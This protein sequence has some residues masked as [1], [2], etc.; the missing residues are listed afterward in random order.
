ML[1]ENINKVYDVKGTKIV[2][3]K[4][5]SFE[6]QTKGFYFITGE[7]GSGKSTLLNIIGG[8]E[9]ASSGE[10]KDGYSL[11]E[12]G[13]VFQDNNLINEYT[14]KDNLLMVGANIEDVKQIL[15]KFDLLDKLNIQVKY[16]SGGE[17]QRIS[18]AR[19]IL[20][21]VKCLL[22]DEITS[23]L[24]E[25]NAKLIFE[26][27]KSLANDMLVILVSHDY[28]NAIK[29]CD[30]CLSMAEGKLI[31]VSTYHNN[32]SSNFHFQF[33]NKTSQKFNFLWQVKYAFRLLKNRLFLTFISCLIM[34]FC[35]ISIFILSSYLT[36]NKTAVLNKSLQKKDI[37]FLDVSTD[38]SLAGLSNRKIYKGNNLV[39]LLENGPA[40]VY[41]YILG[42]D[43]NGFSFK[44]Y[45]TNDVNNLV[46]TDY[47]LENIENNLNI[48]FGS[49]NISFTYLFDNCEVLNTD[50]LKADEEVLVS[51]YSF[52]FLNMDLFKEILVSKN[53]PLK[54][55]GDIR[56]AN[57]IIEE[58]DL[59][60]PSF[61]KD[62]FS[63]YAIYNSEEIIDGSSI[64]NKYD[65]VTS[66]NISLGKISYYS[67][68]KSDYNTY[69][70]DIID[71]S[72]IVA[73]VNITGLT[74]NNSS[75]Y[76]ISKEFY[77]EIIDMGLAYLVSGYVVDIKDLNADSIA[78]M[79][80]YFTDN[81]IN[82][83]DTMYYGLD[84]FNNMYGMVK[85]IVL[86]LSL[87][88]LIVL[89]A[90]LI[91][92]INSNLRSKEKEL[93]ILKIYGVRPQK[94]F[95]SLFMKETMTMVLA[96]LVGLLSS[97]FI[98]NLIDKKIDQRYRNFNYLE[99]HVGPTLAILLG[100]V[101]VVLIISSIVFINFNRK[102]ININLKNN[103]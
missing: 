84:Y 12:I 19:G 65:I 51:Q 52:G 76:Y 59:L 39:N 36:F 97:I 63:T 90:F 95:V 88:L 99:L 86:P 26:L 17:K 69:L 33:A 71:M 35:L 48:N 49:N 91:Y 38:V 56:P 25:E 21:K 45:L 54:I 10:I 103:K 4:D 30:F 79:V 6:F 3:L 101:L 77:K 27:L 68:S 102:E 8:L 64:Q 98:V 14:V 20:K 70:A 61:Y 94:L 58:G 42:Y 29:Y 60:L 62:S 100:L 57:I 78:N 85:G 41:P 18:I 81:N 43:I 92:E 87:I 89:I 44:I 15:E 47:V 66:K 13:I 72:S 93:L 28:D 1:L 24:D 23:N 40:K 83:S 80:T 9:K 37:T 31:D 55:N 16:L 82:F 34:L 32:V 11:N 50:Y 75:D 96:Y 7:S 74:D 46:L 2:A 5:I 67:L 53:I 73:E 22:L